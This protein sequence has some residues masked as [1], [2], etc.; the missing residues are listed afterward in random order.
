MNRIVSFSFP[1]SLLILTLIVN[2]N[3]IAAQTR[4]DRSTPQ[5]KNTPS[6]QDKTKDASLGDGKSRSASK[7]IKQS[8]SMSKEDMV[9]KEEKSGLLVTFI[10][11]PRVQE[12][13]NTLKT[14]VNLVFEQPLILLPLSEDLKYY[15]LWSVV[16]REMGEAITPVKNKVIIR[17]ADNNEVSVAVCINSP[18]GLQALISNAN[19]NQL[20]LLVVAGSSNL[21]R[22]V[23]PKF[24]KFIELHAV[25]KLIQIQNKD[26]L[27]GQ[28]G[29]MPVP[30]FNAEPLQSGVEAQ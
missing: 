24:K 2:G 11:D 18:E 30:A 21:D 14:D 16:S 27:P 13:A 12:L 4:P 23:T 29:S 6:N 5:Q 25:G 8:E 15:K 10:S 20:K 19:V 26:F 1:L 22:V 28:Y 3:D 17:G 9:A 7:A